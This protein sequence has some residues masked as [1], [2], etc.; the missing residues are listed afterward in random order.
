MRDYICLTTLKKRGWSKKMLERLYP[1]P[2]KY[3]TNPYYSNA[4]SMKLYLASRVDAIESTI[5]FRK[6]RQANIRKWAKRKAGNN[7]EA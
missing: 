6:M 5:E 7:K 1:Y 4:E 2:D 3:K